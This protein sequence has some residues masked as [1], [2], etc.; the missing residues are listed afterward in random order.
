MQWIIDELKRELELN[1]YKL[2]K[3]M[4]VGDQA[5]LDVIRQKIIDLEK[6]IKMLEAA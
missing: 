5:G 2:E 3:W 6:A 4:P 1:K